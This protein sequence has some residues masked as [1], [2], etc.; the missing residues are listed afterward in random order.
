MP[1]NLFTVTHVMKRKRKTR[2][3]QNIRRYRN[4]DAEKFIQL[5]RMR[6]RQDAEIEQMDASFEKDW[7]DSQTLFEFAVAKNL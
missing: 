2:E 3:K 5:A 7:D 6:K 1:P 4:A